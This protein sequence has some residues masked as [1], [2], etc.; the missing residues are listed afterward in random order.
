MQIGEQHLALA[1]PCDLHRLRLLHL[2]DQVGGGKN[3]VRTIE[4]PCAS[5]TISVIGDADAGSGIAFHDDVVTQQ[6]QL[7]RPGRAQADPVLVGLNFLW[8]ADF[9]A[10]LLLRPAES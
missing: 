8:N 7:A 5:G 3:L 9:H 1:Q 4:H 2:H 10:T 6:D